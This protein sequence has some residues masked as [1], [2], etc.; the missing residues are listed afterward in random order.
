MSEK[1]KYLTPSDIAVIKCGS[2]S[3][4]VFYSDAFKVLSIDTFCR[5]EYRFRFS[6]IQRLISHFYPI[7]DAL[8]LKSRC[9]EKRLVIAFDPHRRAVKWFARL[10]PSRCVVAVWYWN[11]FHSRSKVTDFKKMGDSIYGF[12]FDPHDALAHG[13]SFADQFFPFDRTEGLKQMGGYAHSAFFVG[14]EKG[15]LPQLCSIADSLRSCGWECDFNILFEDREAEEMH[16]EWALDEAMN[17]ME[18][19]SSVAVNDIVIDFV[20]PGQSGM[21]VRCLEALCFGKKII[22]NN[23]LLTKED[24]WNP[25]NV[26]LAQDGQADGDV[27]RE[28][29]ERPYDASRDEEL[30]EKYSIKTWVEKLAVESLGVKGIAWN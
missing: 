8:T 14:V 15:R 22:T 27:M 13:L 3:F 5:H 9:R 11:V 7:L 12:T 21:T 26:L 10:K 17:Y 4:E 30:K 24:V 19:L 29:L 2:D 20:K 6:P 25:F 23:P 1:Q 16:P 28:F 18:V